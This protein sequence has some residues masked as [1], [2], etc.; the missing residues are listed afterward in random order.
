MPLFVIVHCVHISKHA[1]PGWRNPMAQERCRL[2]EWQNRQRTAEQAARLIKDGMTVGMS[3]FTLA[4]EAKEVPIALAE[5]AAEEPLSI[6]FLTSAS[7]GNGIDGKLTDAGVIAR[8]MP[9]QV[10]ATLQQAINEGRVMFIDGHLSEMVERLRH[11]D[12]PHIDVA[13]IEACAITEDGGIVPTTSVGNSPTFAQL[14]DQ[15]IVEV[16][17][18]APAGLEGLHDIYIPDARPKR[19]PIPIVN[20]GSRIGANAI[21]VDAD[22][23]AAI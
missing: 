20:V 6:N 10:D 8:R 4:G 16:N 13:L 19:Q 1:Q 18:N 7:L 9:V 5:R 23:I 21:P 3:G 17:Q 14:A 2:P 12:L 15:I 22:K 11:G